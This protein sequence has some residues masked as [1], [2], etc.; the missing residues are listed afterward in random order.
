M[1]TEEGYETFVI[2]DDV[3]GRYSVLTAVGLLP[4]ATAGLDIDKMMEGAQHAADKYNNAD[5]ATNQS[6]QYAVV[7]NALYRKGKTI[8]LLVNYEPALHYVSEWWKQFLVKVKEKTKKVY[9]QHLLIFQLT[10]IQWDNM[11]KKAVEI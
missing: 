2:P 10:C 6:Y 3:G 5:L 4:I 9:S 7:R 1:L 8:E 11:C